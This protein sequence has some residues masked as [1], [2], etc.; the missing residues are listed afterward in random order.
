[1]GRVTQHSLGFRISAP[2]GVRGNDIGHVTRT[3]GMDET[4][5]REKDYYG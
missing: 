3:T 5:G 1:M 2:V 4:F